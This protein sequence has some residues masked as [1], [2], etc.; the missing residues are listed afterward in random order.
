MYRVKILPLRPKHSSAGVTKASMNF[1]HRLFDNTDITYEIVDNVSAF[2]D[3]CMA[4]VLIESDGVLN[5]F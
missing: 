5:E 2:Y 1:L 4:L 3:N